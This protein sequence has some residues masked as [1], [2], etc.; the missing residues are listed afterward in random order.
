M[1]H[2]SN[3]PTAFRHSG[4]QLRD[5]GHIFICYS[6]IDGQVLFQLSPH[7]PL[8]TTHYPF[9]KMGSC[10]HRTKGNRKCKKFTSPGEHVC[11]IHENAVRASC[12]ERASAPWQNLCLGCQVDM[13]P[14][15]PRQYCRKTYCP[16]VEFEHF[17][18]RT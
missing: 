5:L 11:W 2:L 7:Y 16:D 18:E 9:K 12:P 13:G 4:I 10:T 14:D 17:H 3:F 8:L 1:E 15:N 6:V